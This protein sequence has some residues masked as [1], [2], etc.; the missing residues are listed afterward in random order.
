MNIA[1]EHYLAYGDKKILEQAYGT[2]K[3]WLE[4]LQ[5]HVK[6]GMLVSYDSHGYFIGDWLGPGQRQE[7]GNT[8]EALFFNNCAY[9]MTLDLFI[10]IAG[11]L[12]RDNETAPYR[13]RLT[14]LRT[15][16]HETYFNPAV[17]SY[18]NGDQV[19]TSFALFAGIFPDSLRPA[20][21]KHLEEDMT[22]AHPYFDIGSSSRY[23]YFKTLF[24]YPQFHEIISGILSKTSKPGY[25]YILSQGE[26][27][28]TEV[29]EADEPA[30]I[31][32]SYT[33]ISAWFIKGLAGIEPDI[34][35]P[36]YRVFTIR[37]HIVKRLDYA[38]AAVES[39]YGLIESAWKRNG[40]KIDYEISVPIGSEARI[41][42]P[43]TA[44]QITENGQP[45]SSVQGVEVIEEKDGYVQ[46]YAQSGKYK[47]NTK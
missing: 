13:E 44:A 31:H 35:G 7:Y 15:R 10:H 20:A 29:W 47:F 42:L 17:N 27:A 9:A 16:L 26:T 2:G 25:G 23:P 1:W 34:E 4:F 5:T 38:K 21:L 39:P 46:I 19:R 32:T 41:Y 36:G 22:G 18:L 3:R 43:A 45:L 30:R 24:A 28:W 40:D 37:P 12:D 8:V 14:T 33:G 11:L 6:D